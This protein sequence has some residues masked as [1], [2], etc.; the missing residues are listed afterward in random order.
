MMDPENTY[1]SYD[2]VIAPD[3]LLYPNVVIEGRRIIKRNRHHFKF[4]DTETA[5][6]ESIA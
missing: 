3:V 5:L 2:A 1:I 4:I 6:S